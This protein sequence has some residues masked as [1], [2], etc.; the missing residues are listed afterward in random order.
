VASLEELFDPDRLKE[1]HVPGG[2]KP[3][4]VEAHAIKG[5]EFGL[6]LKPVEREQLIAFLRTL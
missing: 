4:G 5:H 2:W 1:T 3:P 6:G